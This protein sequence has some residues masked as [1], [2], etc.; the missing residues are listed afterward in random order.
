MC[1][2]LDRSWDLIYNFEDFCLSH[3]NKGPWFWL[4]VSFAFNCYRNTLHIDWD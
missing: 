2:A 4:Q 1:R 3:R